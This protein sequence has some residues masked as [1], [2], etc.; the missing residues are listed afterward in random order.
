MAYSSSSNGSQSSSGGGGSSSNTSGTNE[1]V[2]VSSGSNKG[3]RDLNL[4]M[5]PHPEKRDIIP[6]K[7]AAA[8]KNSVRNLILTNFFERPFQPSMGGN[9]RGLLFEP[10]DTITRL[11]LEDGIKNTL[12]RFEPRIENINISV[13]DVANVQE[14]RVVLVFSIKEDDSVQDL[15]INLRRLR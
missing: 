6:L 7:D 15:E 8:V 1:S 9:L 5:I 2:R 10:A 13:K 12:E 4:Q 3:Y 11:A 14:Y